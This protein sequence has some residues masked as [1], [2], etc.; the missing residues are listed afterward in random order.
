MV[1]FNPSMQLRKFFINDVGRPRSG[2]RLLVFV[3]VFVAVSFLVGLCLRIAYAL[4]HQFLPTVPH[5][6]FIANVIYRLTLL[7]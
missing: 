7:F 6:A 4:G 3:C 5:G 2:W 1:A